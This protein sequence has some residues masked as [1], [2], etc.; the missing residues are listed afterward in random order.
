[1]PST[2]RSSASTCDRP[3]TPALRQAPTAF[4]HLVPGYSVFFAFFSGALMAET[5][6]AERVSAAACGASSAC[7]SGAPFLA[8]KALPYKLD[9][10]VAGRRRLSASTLLFDYDLGEAPLASS[11]L[12]VAPA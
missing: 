9:R 7:P 11:S 3:P 5:I 6:F 4:D 1:M 10:H 12:I 2:T 8:G